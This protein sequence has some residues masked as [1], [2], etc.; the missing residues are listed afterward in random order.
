M[1][2][3]LSVFFEKRLVG[4]LTGESFTYEGS[5]V[6]TGF[7]IGAALPLSTEPYRET[8][9]HWFG[10]LLPE[11]GT[12]E[13]IA[14]RFRVSPDD[15]FA[16]LRCLGR[17]CAGALTIVPEGSEPAASTAKY[18]KLTEEEVEA[19]VSGADTLVLL[20]E[21]GRLSLAGAQDKLPVFRG[22]DASLQ[23]PLDGAPSSHIL[24]FP[25]RD[26]GN[27]VAN[28]LYCLRLARTVGLSCA[29]AEIVHLHGVPALLVER[30][31][32][33][34][35]DS[36]SI[37]RIHQEDFT[38][39]LGRSRHH[40]YE[41]ERGPTLAECAH[42]I[43]VTGARPAL[44]IRELLRWVAFNFFIGNRDNHAKNV[45][46]LLAQT[47]P[48]TWQLAPFYDLVNTT[49]YK[50]LTRK[51]AFFVGGEFEVTRVRKPQWAAMAVDLGVG[52]RFLEDEVQGVRERIREQLEPTREAV[53]QELG[54][55]AQLA[56]PFRAINKAIRL[57]VEAIG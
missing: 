29:Q 54:D 36:G 22:E 41:E 38:Q 17:E 9:R 42:L 15:D 50:S 3:R 34:R 48:T 33:K 11:G 51:L 31:D 39:A 14:R 52:A 19:L 46:R 18:R 12:R 25:N 45:S 2:E 13:R 28:E 6:D 21:E 27:L 43:R 4:H 8:A 32:R 35:A 26:F 49:G 37:E 55:E 40:K 44:E 30:Y 16:L 24:K 5:W 23:I 56:A 53:V 1:S 20:Q 57:G 47:H 7:P 10:N